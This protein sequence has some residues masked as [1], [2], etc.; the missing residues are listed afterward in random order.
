[1]WYFL[2]FVFYLIKTHP[3][4]FCIFIVFMWVQSGCAIFG[5]HQ[6]DYEKVLFLEYVIPRISSL[7]LQMCLLIKLDKPAITLQILLFLLTLFSPGVVSASHPTGAISKVPSEWVT[8]FSFPF[9][10]PLSFL[11]CLSLNTGPCYLSA[12]PVSY[13]QPLDWLVIVQCC[14]KSSRKIFDIQISAKDCAPFPGCCWSWTVG[15]ITLLNI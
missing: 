5:F 6:H 1:M 8:P 2:F 11:P 3:N 10:F 12:L 7:N 14:Y 4:H 13:L 15:L 9:Y